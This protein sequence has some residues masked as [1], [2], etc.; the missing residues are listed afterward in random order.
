[1]SRSNVV[2]SST[3]EVAQ[4]VG[5]RTRGRA[6]ASARR[7]RAGTGRAAA[8]PRRPAAGRAGAASGWRCR[9]GSCWCGRRA[10]RGSRSPGSPSWR[11][12]P[13]RRRARAPWRSRR[14]ARR[15]PVITSVT[16][17]RP[18]AV[19]VRAG[20]GERGD[21]RHRDVVAEQ[22]RRRA[23]AAAAAVEDHVVDADL[24]RGVEVVLD[25]LR[26]Q[27]EAD[28]DAARL[29]RAPRRRSGG[30]RRATCQSG[31]RRRRDRGRALGQAAHLGD[32]ARRPCRRAGGRR[33]RSSRPGRP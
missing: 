32:P 16:S 26:R 28:R 12:R 17:R 22:Q 33:F 23:G 4:V 8:P 24:E 18:A 15:P 7:S 31:K 30:S 29:P 10:C 11:P 9:P 19:E 27:L 1:M 20:A 25:V 3:A 2:R 5:G 14:R 13:R 6:P 21:G